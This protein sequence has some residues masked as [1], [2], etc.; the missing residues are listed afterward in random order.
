[1]LS[2]SLLSLNPFY[3]E[4]YLM[5]ATSNPF[6]KQGLDTINKH[7]WVN[8]GAGQGEGRIIEYFL[9]GCS[10]ISLKYLQGLCHSMNLTADKFFLS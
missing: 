3:L 5:E 7:I 2:C 4:F 9:S 1:M 10:F 8:W 6:G